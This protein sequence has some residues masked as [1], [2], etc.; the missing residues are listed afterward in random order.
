V[1][2]L[3]YRRLQTRYAGNDVDNGHLNLAV[4]FEF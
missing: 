1:T 3:E 2:G 4:G